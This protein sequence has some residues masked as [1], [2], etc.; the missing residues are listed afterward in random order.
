MAKNDKKST[1][2]RQWDMLKLLPSGRTG[3]P[4]SGRW[5]KASE[6]RDK[7]NEAGYRVSVRT[8]QRDLL[9]LSEVFPIE[10]NDKN[11]RDY[12]WRWI[13]GAHLDL[14]GMGVAEALALRLV[15]IHLR[16]LMPASL[17]DGL[18]AV[19]G[20][21]RSKLN[22][23]ALH[24]RNPG[25]NWPDK[26]RVVPPAQPLLPPTVKPEIQAEIYRS[27]LNN[28]QIKVFY[29]PVCQDQPKEYR[30]P[31]LGLILR[32]AVVYLAASAWSYSDVQLYALHRFSSVE[33]LEEPVRVPEGFGLDQA[34]AKGLAEFSNRGEPIQLEIRC[35]EGVAAFLAETPLA[36]DQQME[37]EA[38]GWT[39]LTATVNDT[40]QLHWWLLGQ[41][42]GIEVIGPAELREGIRNELINAVNLYGK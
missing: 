20:L 26:I 13:K 10:L 38:G 18:E 24:N 8:V 11:P 2:L 9:Q 4:H 19:F 5:S 42:A 22:V 21:A 40:W 17:F 32:G 39:R 41:G 7:L 6:I 1:L 14:P 27:V 15:E 37:P 28:Q 36:A 16:Q 12:G 3:D 23:L 25:K 31:P 34:L 30:L 33:I 29:Q 35:T